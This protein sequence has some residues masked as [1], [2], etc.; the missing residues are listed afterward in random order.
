MFMRIFHIESIP[1]E[2]NSL[3]IK[4]IPTY[5]VDYSKTM[6]AHYYINHCKC[7]AKLGD[8][9]MHNESQAEHFFLCTK[10]VHKMI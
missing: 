9:Y 6:N 3:L 5:Y 8:F 4:L 1:K 7:G 2:L 10:R